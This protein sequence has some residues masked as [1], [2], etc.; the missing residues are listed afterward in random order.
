MMESA[1]KLQEAK[2]RL[3][4]PIDYLKARFT[5]R[6]IFRYIQSHPD[7]DHMAGLHRLCV[8][9]KYQVVN[10][11]DTKHCIQKDEDALRTGAS[12]HDINDWH[13]Y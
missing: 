4:N 10:M 12:N 3:T 9:E 11:W 7:M 2:D 1:R 5:P 13:T 8:D 6:S